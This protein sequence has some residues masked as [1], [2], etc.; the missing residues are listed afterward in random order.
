MF[1]DFCPQSFYGLY[2]WWGLPKKGLQAFLESNQPLGVFMEYKDEPIA[3]WVVNDYLHSFAGSSIVWMVSD[4]NGSIVAQG[5]HKLDITPDSV[6]KVT[7]LSF[8]I[9]PES[10]YTVSLYV[11]NGEGQQLAKNIYKDAFH[12]P[13][14]PNGHPH[15]MNHELGVRLYWA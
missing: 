11:R 8:S 15:R 5:E 7:D 13:V 4:E 6:Q 12:H 10:S 3:I 9:K 1:I 2:D 14:H